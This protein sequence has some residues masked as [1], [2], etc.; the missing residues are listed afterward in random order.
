MARMTKLLNGAREQVQIRIN[1]KKQHAS[2]RFTEGIK[3]A[4]LIAG[5]RGCVDKARDNRAS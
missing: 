2:S 5:E 4:E 3:A 1:S